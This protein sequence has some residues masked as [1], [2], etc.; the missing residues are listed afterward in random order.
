MRCL[1]SANAISYRCG[2]PRESAELPLGELQAKCSPLG[3]SAAAD[4]AG[5]GICLG[6]LA[7]NA[8][9]SLGGGQGG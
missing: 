7:L 3:H 1:S 8:L 2:S 9:G 5:L 6:R 4:V